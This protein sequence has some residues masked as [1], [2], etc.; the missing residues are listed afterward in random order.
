MSMR[1]TASLAIAREDEHRALEAADAV[2][3]VAGAYPLLTWR[4]H[5]VVGAWNL[6][7]RPVEMLAEAELVGAELWGKA[8]DAARRSLGL[9]AYAVVDID[10]VFPASLQTV[11]ETHGPRRYTWRRLCSSP[12]T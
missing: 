12:M 10:L 5:L 1:L 9:P 6:Q 4:G 8:L 11:R 3:K 7:S 2:V